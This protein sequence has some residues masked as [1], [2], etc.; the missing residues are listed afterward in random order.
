M[1][2][3]T[4][5]KFGK[6]LFFETIVGIVIILMCLFVFTFCT[7][8]RAQDDWMAE[9]S[10][11]FGGCC[12]KDDCFRV[13]ARITQNLPN[14][15]EIEVNGIKM[16]VPKTIV[17]ASQDTSSYWCHLSLAPEMLAWFPRELPVSHCKDGTIS[18]ECAHCVF[19]AVGS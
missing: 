16:I 4:S 9:F 10:G 15:F 7:L 14:N 3:M 5:Q 17:R 8:A 19:I 13:S 1:I 11:T 18:Q 6:K 12:G 2:K